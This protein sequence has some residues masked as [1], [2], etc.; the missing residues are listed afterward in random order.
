[1]PHTSLKG[2]TLNSSSLFVQKDNAAMTCRQR[3]RLTFILL[4]TFSFYKRF[5]IRSYCFPVLTDW[6]SLLPWHLRCVDFNSCTH[7]TNASRM[8]NTEIRNSVTGESSQDPSTQWTR[9]IVGLVS[10]KLGFPVPKWRTKFMALH[11]SSHFSKKYE[12]VFQ[13]VS[14]M[15][16]GVVNSEQALFHVSQILNWNIFHD[17]K[18]KSYKFEVLI[19]IQLRLFPPTHN[20]KKMH[21]QIKTW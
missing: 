13:A 21:F 12:S 15:F 16:F 6:N 10:H 2:E 20:Y 18:L 19:L 4:F 17:L 7:A 3:Y 9:T 8:L 5:V 11:T 14:S 1:M